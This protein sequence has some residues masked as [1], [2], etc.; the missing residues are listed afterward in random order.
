MQQEKQCW[1]PPGLVV[2]MPPGWPTSRGRVPGFRARLCS[3]SSFPLIR[4]HPG[5]MFLE[6]REPGLAWEALG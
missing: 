2:K 6:D 1:W 3:E 4:T 5:R